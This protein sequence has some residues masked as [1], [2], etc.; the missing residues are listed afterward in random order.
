MKAAT[1]IAGVFALLGLLALTCKLLKPNKD[2][3]IIDFGGPSQVS[4]GEQAEFW[5]DAVDPDSDHVSYVWSCTRGSLSSDSGAIIRW[6]SPEVSGRDTL[7]VTA[8]DGRGGSA[9]AD[10]MVSVTPSTSTVAHWDGIVYAREYTY[11]LA[12]IGAGHLIH[13]FFSV[14]SLDITFLVLG[15]GD[16]V[17]WK[18][19][20][21]YVPEIEIDRS[22]G[23]SIS[24]TLAESGTY[25]FVLDNTYSANA[26][27]YGHLLLQATSP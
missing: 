14:D 20:Q 24:A 15:A 2:P 10:K 8:A 3:V 18:N 6:S 17:K 9:T 5:C 27:K 13:G 1:R 12:Q 4:A 16:F 26:N 22:P 21:A 7:F 23:D 25:Y 11:T 19:G